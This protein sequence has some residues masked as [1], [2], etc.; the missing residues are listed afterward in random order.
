MNNQTPQPP[1]GRGGGVVGVADRLLRPLENAFNLLAAGSI[2]FLMLLAVAQVVGR[3]AFNAP[4]PGFID[5]VEQAMVMFAFL[6]VAYCQ[7]EGGHIRMDLVLGRLHGRWPWLSELLTTLLTLFLIVGLIYG[8]WEHFLRAWD[9]GDST[10]DIGLPIWPSK[11]LVPVT[12]GLLALRLVIQ[13]LGFV[14]LLAKPDAEPIGVPRMESVEE[15]ARDEIDE[16]MGDE[17]EE[18]GESLGGR[19]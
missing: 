9:F 13:V 18:A 14:R 11:L 19:Q 15:H 4:I 17:E 12:L 2:L 5:F 10:I 8:S 16:V 3:A 1:A 6:G 7:R